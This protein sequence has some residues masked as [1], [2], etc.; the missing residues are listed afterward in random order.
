MCSI[1]EAD[2]AN[3]IDGWIVS[4]PTIYGPCGGPVQRDSVQIP[5][6]VKLAL[7]KN[8]AVYLGDGTATWDNVRCSFLSIASLTLRQQVH[9]EDLVDLYDLVLAKAL[10]AETRSTKISPYAKF[11]LVSSGKHTW[12]EMTEIVARAM[13]KRGVIPSAE[14]HK[15]TWEEASAISSWALYVGTNS[16]AVPSRARELGWKPKHLDWRADVDADVEAA[17]RTLGKI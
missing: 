11:I 4:P 15:I 9:V 10:A 7:A 16:F 8:Q 6:I 12:G 13:H 1:F 17:L 5:L 14:T 3:L 2:A